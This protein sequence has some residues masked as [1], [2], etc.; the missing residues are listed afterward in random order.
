MELAERLK[1]E[2]AAASKNTEYEEAMQQMRMEWEKEKAQYQS[3]CAQMTQRLT[4]ESNDHSEVIKRLKLEIAQKDEMSRQLLEQ[5]K[6]A[7]R[8]PG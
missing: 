2:A 7:M 3:M 1:R 4:I 6:K 8:R 5:V